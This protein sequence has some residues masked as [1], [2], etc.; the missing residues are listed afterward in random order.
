[1]S[2]PMRDQES[3]G[4][5]L[6]RFRDY[7]FANS[8]PQYHTALFLLLW[9]LLVVPALQALV[10]VVSLL[11]SLTT[12]FVDYELI[13]IIIGFGSLAELVRCHIKLWLGYSAE[14][15]CY[16]AMP[17]GGAA[18]GAMFAGFVFLK[19]GTTG[20][21]NVSLFIG[22][23]AGIYTLFGWIFHLQAKQN[24]KQQTKEE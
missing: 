22:G 18:F 23:G 13:G 12:H 8:R 19:W 16:P 2:S 7:L 9:A 11:P 24:A 1:M 6:G 3:V 20:W 14:D 15:W 4:E 21:L 17:V 10:F 5:Q